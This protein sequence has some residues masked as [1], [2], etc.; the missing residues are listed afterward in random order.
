MLRVALVSVLAAVAPSIT[1]AEEVDNQ[2]Y[3]IDP[4]LTPT[5][6]WELDSSAGMIQY[7]V[8]RG[9]EAP[10]PFYWELAG[11][12]VGHEC[13]LPQDSCVTYRVPHPELLRQRNLTANDYIDNSSVLPSEF[14]ID[15]RG[16]N[17]TPTRVWCSQSDPV[18]C[19]LPRTDGYWQGVLEFF[20]GRRLCEGTVSVI[21]AE[22][23]TASIL[24]DAQRGSEREG[25]E[26]DL[27]FG[28]STTVPLSGLL[29]LSFP[30]GEAQNVTLFSSESG[31]SVSEAELS[32][33]AF[34]SG[35]FFF[36]ESNRAFEIDVRSESVRFTV[37][38]YSGP[39]VRVSYALRSGEAPIYFSPFSVFG[40]E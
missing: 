32:G 11:F 30:E 35:P 28:I 22:Y 37:R 19:H 16:G 34:E 25:G 18:Y 40:E 9:E 38:D 14:T 26:A 21:E 12:G 5:P 24:F 33:S 7:R 17:S 20:L 1:A 13:L 10:A 15:W 6:E 23:V 3:G 2:V 27:S 8:C 39:P 36:D 31:D 4:E 29:I